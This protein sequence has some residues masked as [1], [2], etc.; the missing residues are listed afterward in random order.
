VGSNLNQRILI[1]QDLLAQLQQIQCV[2]RGTSLK[3]SIFSQVLSSAT[4]EHSQDFVASVAATNPT[5]PTP[6]LTF[7]FRLVG[8]HVIHANAPVHPKA[9]LKIR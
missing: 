3:R 8:L 6:P 1:L 5:T 7:C 9:T 2:H 4:P